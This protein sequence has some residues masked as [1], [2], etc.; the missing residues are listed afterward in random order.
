M[1]TLIESILDD[2]PNVH[3]EGVF[4]D[5]IIPEIVK[6]SPHVMG[7]MA[8]KMAIKLESGKR[9]LYSKDKS[10]ELRI[11]RGVV[12]VLEEYN[13]H[14]IR[15][16]GTVEIAASLTKFDISAPHVKLSMN[17]REALTIFKC[18]ITCDELS[19]D[20][21]NK[22][23]IQCNQCQI[24]TKSYKIRRTPI[25]FNNS[26]IIGLDGVQ[27]SFDALPIRRTLD[28]LGLFYT[29]VSGFYTG[30]S[31]DTKVPHFDPLKELAGI[32]KIAKLPNIYLYTSNKAFEDHMA[33]LIFKSPRIPIDKQVEKA[34]TPNREPVDCANG[35][36]LIFNDCKD[37]VIH[38]RRTALPR[39]RWRY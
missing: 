11:N 20:G 15:S 1:R 5:Q 3:D 9:I 23:S 37:E 30:L 32:E 8:D 24:K 26:K 35:Y 4:T 2:D 7:D 33:R 27:L 22:P 28:G 25:E 19:V 12:Q 10:S 31:F 21:F 13:I 14:E 38:A 18:N 6:C 29:V 16:E 36:Q 39:G 34:S 17:E